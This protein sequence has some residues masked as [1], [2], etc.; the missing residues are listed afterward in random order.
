[1]A[2]GADRRRLVRAVAAAAA[3]GLVIHVLVMHV[4]LPALTKRMTYE[5]V[6]WLATS[7]AEHPVAVVAA[8]VLFAAVLALPVLGAFRWAYGPFPPRAR[9]GRAD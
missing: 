9:N 2:C 4:A 5:H 8:V 7:F 6:E 3:T 1:M